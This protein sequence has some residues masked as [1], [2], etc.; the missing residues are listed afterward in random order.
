[1]SVHHA[2]IGVGS[3]L[4][5][6]L[7]QVEQ[8]FAA[9]ATI[10]DTYLVNRSPLYISEPSGPVSQPPYVNAVVCLETEKEPEALLAELQAI[11]ERQG[12]VRTIRWGP[13]TLDL[14]ILLYGGLIQ[15]H[16]ELVLPHPR[17]HERAF[18]LYPLHDIAPKLFIPGYGSLGELLKICPPR[19]LER[20]SG[21]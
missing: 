17:M 2:Y 4:E 13:R 15:N 16:P 7:A 8:A 10:Q 1:M 9:L 12:R 19:G 18:V 14:D 11:E 3:N 6:P 5:N 20:L 21:V